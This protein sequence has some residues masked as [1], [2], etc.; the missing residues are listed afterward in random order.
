MTEGKYGMLTI[1][2]FSHQKGRDFYHMCKCD[3][4]NER[5]MNVRHILGGGS[6]TCGCSRVR[7]SQE[8]KFNIALEYEAGAEVIDVATKYNA[9]I[10]VAQRAIKEFGVEFRSVLTDEQREEIKIKY[11]LG[12]ETRD[13][14]KEYGVSSPCIRQCILDLGG[15]MRAP[16]TP[17]IM[18]EEEVAFAKDMY[19]SGERST[20]ISEAIGAGTWVVRLA[21]KKK[22]VKMR[23]PE[24]QPRKHGLNEDAFAEPTRDALY[25]AGFIAADGCIFNNQLSISLQTRDRDHLVK[26]KEFVGYGKD[27]YKEKDREAYTI[28]FSSLKMCKDLAKYG[29]TPRKSLT[30]DPPKFCRES[31]DFWRGIV[32]GDG[33]VRIGLDGKPT[34]G[35]VGSYGAVNGFK[36]WVKKLTDTKAQGGK[37]G[38]IYVFSIYGRHAIAVIN[39]MQGGDPK[40]FLDR[41]REAVK[42]FIDVHENV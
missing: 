15:K 12:M 13:L 19:E 20:D 5:I 26:F 4:G 34:V 9:S 31:A 17:L 33:C 8:D 38:N 10:S 11:E 14:K 28:K 25:W 22:G 3:C 30:Y 27:P 29:I 18:S 23:T 21:L 36:K 35:F 41:K 7:L 39:Q 42:K 2:E 16:G 24:E 37:E 6:K 1:G 32:D 40:Y